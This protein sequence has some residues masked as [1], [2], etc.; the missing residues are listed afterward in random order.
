[1]ME[2]KILELIRKKKYDFLEKS[3]KWSDKK[4]PAILDEK[5]CQSFYEGQSQFCFSVYS[6]IEDIE[7]EIL[8][9]MEKTSG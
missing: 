3:K 6:I 8:K 5:L 2:E 1:M 7:K 9:M 4:S